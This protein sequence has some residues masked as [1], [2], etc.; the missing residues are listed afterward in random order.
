MTHLDPAAQTA[1]QA[2][3][4]L[5]GFAIQ[6]QF[7]GVGDINL[8][9]GAGF[10]QI[11]ASTFLG[12][13][14]TYGSLVLPER[15]TDGIGAQAPNISF[16]VQVPTNTA[17]AALCNPAA[18]G[19]TVICYYWVASRTTGFLIG[20]PYQLWMGAFDCATLIADKWSRVV[21]ID[22]ESYFGPFLDS[23][24][25]NLLSNADHQAIWPGELG[26][27]FVVDVQEIMPWGQDSP[28]PVMIKDVLTT[29]SPSSGSSVSPGTSVLPG[30]PGNPLSG[31]IGDILSGL[32]GIGEML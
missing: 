16:G 9:D 12:E 1:L 26:L 4:P 17:A 25:G 32:F 23:P 30:A 6:M 13:D 5:H 28:R 24:D 21:K 11:G 20:Q 22:A 19:A 29:P 8:L 31:L 7:P 18:Q 14:P 2:P 10:L 15:F 3:S 27:Q